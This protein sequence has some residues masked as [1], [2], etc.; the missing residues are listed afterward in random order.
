MTKARFLAL[1]AIAVLA[2]SG[3]LVSAT[4]LIV[5]CTSVSGPTELGDNI[6]CPQFSAGLGTL[7][8]VE[9][10]VTGTIT[11]SLTLTNNTA[12]VQRTS[13]TTTS[14]MNVG[15][16]AGFSFVNPIFVASFTT[17]IQSLN[18]GQTVT[19]AG[20]SGSGT[21]SLGTNTSIL[22]PYEGLGMFD[23][24]ISTLSGFSLVGGGGHIGALQVTNATANAV[25]TY[26]YESPNDTGTPEPA[27]M[28]LVG[29]G[30]LALG[31]SAKRLRRS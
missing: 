12:T 4:P 7:L 14:Q 31:W 8:S 21:A 2:L 1:T 18:P 16:L 29:G 24:P 11:G 25:V 15:S 20:L 3:A 10:T 13:A 9:I 30:L 27:S 17:G 6:A 19:F 28:A 5:N 26:N 22:G 23:V